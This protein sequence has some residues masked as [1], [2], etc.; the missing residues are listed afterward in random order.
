MIFLGYLI[1]FC[2]LSIIWIFS[3]VAFINISVNKDII[4]PA[5]YMENQVEKLKLEAKQGLKFD[6]SKIPYSSNYIFFDNKNKVVKANTNEDETKNINKYLNEE[7][8][9]SKYVY[10]IGVAAAPV[11]D[12]GND[13]PFPYR[14]D[15]YLFAPVNGER[16]RNAGKLLFVFR[17]V[18]KLALDVLHGRVPPL[19]EK[20]REL[21]CTILA[22]IAVLQLAVSEK[23]DFL[24]ADVAVFFVKQSHNVILRL[25]IFL[26][27]PF[28]IVD[29]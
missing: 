21:S 16:R 2:I 11:G 6:S 25:L 27:N 15:V 3:L 9:S 4:K 13:E 28:C 22:E 14:I 8:F 23:S 29:L 24:T 12:T 26:Y 5:N 20:R 19:A 1:S 18:S 7:K 10:D 17:T